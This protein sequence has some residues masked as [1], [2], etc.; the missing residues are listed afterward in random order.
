MTLK[1]AL[2]VVIA[3]AAVLVPM[4]DAD[5]SSDFKTSYESIPQEELEELLGDGYLDMVNRN[6]LD[7]AGIR[8][9]GAGCPSIETDISGI[10]FGLDIDSDDSSSLE[11]KKQMETLYTYYLEYDLKLTLR[12]NGAGYD[13]FDEEVTGDAFPFESYSEGDTGTISGH[14]SLSIDADMRETASGQEYDPE[15]FAINSS[16]IIRTSYG[17]IDLDVTFVHDSIPCYANILGG[18]SIRSVTVSDF[19]YPDEED[20]IRPG[21]EVYCRWSS[22]EDSADVSIRFT[23]GDKV[24][25]YNRD[26][27]D[28]YSGT[29]HGSVPDSFFQSPSK[30]STI[31]GYKDAVSYHLDELARG[32][33]SSEYMRDDGLDPYKAP[34]RIEDGI[35]QHAMSLIAAAI[36]IVIAVTKMHEGVFRY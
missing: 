11:E 19:I 17:L 34:E 25:E 30:I 32:E 33:L 27:G 35:W 23:T 3:M 31:D 14:V 9:T 7:K 21:D 8:T 6:V 15:V 13:A 5:G 1:A 20:G 18:W 4:G 28:C 16:T 26:I 36:F 29:S 24:Y 22:R 10:R 12:S 2:L